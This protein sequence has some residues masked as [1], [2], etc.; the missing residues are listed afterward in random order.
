MEDNPA[1]DW[2]VSTPLTV[3]SEWEL[4]TPLVAN[5]LQANHLV[6]TV[7]FQDSRLA[8][9]LPL[10]KV[11]SRV[12]PPTLAV[13]TTQAAALVAV[14]WELQG[15][16]QVKKPKLLIKEWPLMEEVDQTMQVI[17]ILQTQETL[18]HQVAQD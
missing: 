14:V 2:V 17:Q 18:V 13:H 1:V 6:K 12:R 16:L 10:T 11:N 3:R 8:T 7:L 15:A 4:M 9:A 5:Q